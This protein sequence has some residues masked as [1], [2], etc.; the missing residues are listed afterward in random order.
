SLTAIPRNLLE[1]AKIDG[2][3]N[4]DITFRVVIPQLR[5][6]V[7]MLAILSTIT[8]GQWAFNNITILT[9]GGPEYS[10][11]N[12][13]YSIYRLGFQFFETGEASATAM[14]LLAATLAVAFVAYV[15]QKIVV[16]RQVKS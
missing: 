15:V 13:Y 9:G 4:F 3:T 16:R 8:A 2:A 1:A 6:T 11:D 12:I 14:L 5:M 10:T 7:L